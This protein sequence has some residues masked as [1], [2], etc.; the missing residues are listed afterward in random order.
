[1]SKE[2]FVRNEEMGAMRT[3]TPGMILG[4]DLSVLMPENSVGSVLPL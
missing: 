2:V 4:G 3:D 1:M